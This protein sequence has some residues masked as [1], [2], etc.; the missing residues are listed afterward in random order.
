MVSLTAF[1]LLWMANRYPPVKYLYDWIKFLY[2]L[3]FPQRLLIFASSSLLVVSGL[4][5][6]ILFYHVRKG[7]KQYAIS[8]TGRNNRFS[9][10]L[11][12]RDIITLVFFLT[13]LVAASDTY[14]VN[15]SVAFGA[16][17]LDLKSFEALSWLKQYD[18]SLYYTDLGGDLYFWSWAPAAYDLEMPI[19][20]D[21]NQVERLASSYKQSSEDSPFVA[22][23]KYQFLQSNQTPAPGAQLVHDFDGYQLWYYSD[24]LPFAFIVSKDAIETGGKLDHTKA[25]PV[26]V[27]Y[28]GLNRVKV[29]AETNGKPDQLVVLVSDFPGWKLSVDGKPAI[30]TPVN[31]YFGAKLLPGKHTYIFTFDPPLY[32]I[33]FIIT[34]YSIYI[35]LLMILSESMPI[36][37]VTNSFQRKQNSFI[38]TPL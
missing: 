13:L 16:H 31:Y 36:R 15:K 25:I 3:R 28:E 6:Q 20:N 10:I 9:P 14:K 5:L 38:Q 32:R 23:P 2:T 34:L 7:V 22:T 37:M 35:S 21:N 19:I 4:S 1:L 27:K 30:K 29:I 26:E 24:A 11:R 12:L 18:P 8:L 33:G 17:S